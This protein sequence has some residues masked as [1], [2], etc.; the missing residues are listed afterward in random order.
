[1]ASKL[2][3]NPFQTLETEAQAREA[4]QRGAIVA[5]Y[6]GV[7]YII[8]L[9]LAIGWR[10]DFT[11]TLPSG[12]GYFGT[13]VG[14]GVALALATWFLWLM[15]KRQPVWTAWA[16]LVWIGMETLF[17]LATIAGGAGAGAGLIINVI[18]II[19]AI[20]AVRGA[21]RLKTLRKTPVAVFD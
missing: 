11:G 1:M 10:R 7:G 20:F 3:F 14:D 4:A 5:G 18:A 13:I 21:G 12:A 19:Y 16:I 17:K 9:V 8:A 2:G 15:W 6:I